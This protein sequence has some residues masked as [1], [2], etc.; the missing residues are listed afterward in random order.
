MKELN[1]LLAITNS[2]REQI[3]EILDRR[4]N[5]IAG[6][7]ADNRDKAP[8]SV[9]L[10]LSRETTRLRRLS[11]LIRPTRATHDDCESFEKP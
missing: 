8:S 2:A 4:A 3:C 1:E 11:D 5:E 6:F 9:E 10:A 7:N